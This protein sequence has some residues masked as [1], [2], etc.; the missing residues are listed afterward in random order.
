MLLFVEE[1]ARRLC[2]PPL[3]VLLRLKSYSLF[4]MGG[5]RSEFE[6]SDLTEYIP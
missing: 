3:I 1:D 4:V 5:K 2:L 6:A